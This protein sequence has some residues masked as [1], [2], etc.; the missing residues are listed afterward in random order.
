MFAINASYYR[1]YNRKRVIETASYH[2]KVI[3]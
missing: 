3:G 2:K 1:L